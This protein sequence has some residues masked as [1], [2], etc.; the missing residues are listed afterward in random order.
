MEIQASAKYLRISPRKLRL[1]TRGLKGM[2]PTAALVKLQAYPQKGGLF[3]QKLVKQAMAN[4]VNN[5]KLAQSDLTIKNIQVGEG[6]AFKRMDR[7]HGARFD[8]GIIKKRTAHAYITLET[9]GKVSEV[10]TVSKE[11][12]Q[13]KPSK[14]ISPVEEKSEVKEEKKTVKKVAAAKKPAARTR[15]TKKENK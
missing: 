9:K 8:R 10:S 7:S 14:P 4:A 3:L 12:K 1:L 5:F 13:I 6:P 15:T 2:T 11:E